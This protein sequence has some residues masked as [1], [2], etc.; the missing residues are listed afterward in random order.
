MLNYNRP[1]IQISKLRSRECFLS[2]KVSL[3]NDCNDSSKCSK[4]L[5]LSL[6]LFLYCTYVNLSDMWCSFS[7]CY[8]GSRRRH[9][10]L[11]IFRKWLA[12]E[13]YGLAKNRMFGAFWWS[14]SFSS[15]R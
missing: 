10:G 4:Q 12:A 13:I 8:S 14:R 5:L 7:I 9:D 1:D 2:V 15:G 6:E 3:C 11:R